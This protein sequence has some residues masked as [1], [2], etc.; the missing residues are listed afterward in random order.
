MQWCPTWCFFFACPRGANHA[1]PNRLPQIQRSDFSLAKIQAIVK[2]ASGWA[3]VPCMLFSVLVLRAGCLVSGRAV[4]WHVRL[5][6]WLWLRARAA[7]LRVVGWLLAGPP[8][9]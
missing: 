6:L 2:G 5:G 3:L 8:A 7:L 1:P 4:V 9:A